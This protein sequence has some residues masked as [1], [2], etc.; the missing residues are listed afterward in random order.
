MGSFE[1]SDRTAADDIAGIDEAACAAVASEFVEDR[2]VAALED[3]AGIVDVR[4]P[5][6][7]GVRVRG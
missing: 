6:S 1:A 2:I 5:I 3:A 4:P 7:F